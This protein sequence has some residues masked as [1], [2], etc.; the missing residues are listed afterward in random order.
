MTATNASECAC[1]LTFDGSD[2][3]RLAH[4]TDVAI[5]PDRLRLAALAPTMPPAC[6]AGTRDS[7]SRRVDAVLERSRLHRVSRAR[8]S[9][10]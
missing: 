4:R 9:C 6:R 1:G 2:L 7:G 5:C 10:R 3:V 8:P